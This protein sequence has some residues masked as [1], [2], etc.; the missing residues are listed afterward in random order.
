M[1]E[2]AR[3]VSQLRRNTVALISLVVAL[4]S[5]GYNT[6]RNERTEANRNLR[7]A[8]FEILVRLNDLQKT[9]FYLRY[10]QA[11]HEIGNPR[12]GWTYVLSIQDF[13]TVLP[14]PYPDEASQLL[15]VWQHHWESVADKPESGEA[16]Q[17]AIDRMRTQTL[18]LLK[19]LN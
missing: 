11:N 15:Q 4:S 10:E 2:D 17:A 8:S 14:A 7:A 18:A 1:T 12:I 9:L 5:L 3:F 6:W 13:A 19:T 16:I